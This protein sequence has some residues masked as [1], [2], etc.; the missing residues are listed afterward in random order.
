MLMVI[1]GF[2]LGHSDAAFREMINNYNKK[3]NAQ[4]KARSAIMQTHLM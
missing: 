1:E 2:V 3:T 4:E